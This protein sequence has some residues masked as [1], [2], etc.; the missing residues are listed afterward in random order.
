MAGTRHF[1]LCTL[2]PALAAATVALAQPSFPIDTTPNPYLPD[3]SLPAVA[4][5][6]ERFLLAW[7]DARDSSGNG[8]IAC[9]LF[10]TSGTVLAPGGFT[11]VH[12]TFKQLSPAA[13]GLE[14]LYLVVWRDQR[15]DATGDIYGARVTRSGVV[16]DP[17]GIRIC[18]VPGGQS[19]VTV[20]ASDSGW[21]VVWTDTRVGSDVLGARVSLGGAVLD[22]AGI[23]IAPLY[24]S[25]L[26]PAV[27]SDGTDYFVV[28]LNIA[29]ID[30]S[31][32]GVRVSA[33]GQVIGSGIRVAGDNSQGTRPAEPA[34]AFDGTNYLVVWRDRA[35]TNGV[36]GRFVTQDGSLMESVFTICDRYATRPRI[37]FDGVRYFVCWVD[38]TDP[39]I[40]A[41]SVRPDGSV[42]QDPLAVCT[43]TGRQ[44]DIAV[45]A[46]AS[47]YLLAWSDERMQYC[48]YVGG[49]VIDTSGA[50]VRRD[51]FAAQL[52]PYCGNQR[53]VRVCA[54]SETYFGVWES[55]EPLRYSYRTQN[56]VGRPLDRTG[57]AMDRGT[58]GI[59]IHSFY[60]DS[61]PVVAGGDS[62][63]L[64]LY[65]W[66]YHGVMGV[67]VSKSGQILDP[68]GFQVFTFGTAQ[69]DVCFGGGHFL[70]VASNGAVRGALVSE[71]GQ[72][73]SP[74]VF[75]IIEGGGRPHVAF[76][77]TNFLVTSSDGNGYVYCKRVDTL[78]NVIDPQP[79]FLGQSHIYT[80]DPAVA[81][82][83]S[84]YLVTWPYYNS[85]P[86]IRAIR[87]RPN[88][89]VMDTAAFVV[90]DTALYAFSPST[91]RVCFDGR[92]FVVVWGC[93][94]YWDDSTFVAGV[95]IAQNGSIGTRFSLR[96][97][98]QDAGGISPDLVRGPG[99]RVLI[100]YCDVWDQP[101]PLLGKLRTYGC[102]L[103]SLVG[104]SELGPAGVE[105]TRLTASPNPFV[106][107][108]RINVSASD[109]G[110]R[111]VN[112]AG[113]AVRDLAGAGVLNWDGRDSRGVAVP[114]GVYFCRP[115]GSTSTPGL[116]LV[117]TE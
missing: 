32:C 2:L 4:S 14:S 101:G 94:A 64:A 96:T 8:D 36:R 52:A 53:R 20:A 37:V 76:D 81:F 17:A 13:A 46:T 56:T 113:Q 83:D 75:T 62:V 9:V 92:D 93:D 41:I 5:D 68:T 100:A 90:S 108:T 86:S 88:L 82:G 47:R 69:I 15:A 80:G 18:G 44:G 16:L 111:I 38:G 71:A 39:N 102:F 103:D 105:Q 65:Y 91:P 21:L 12:D 110:T 10:D 27:A 34:V 97:R 3:Q 106:R 30:S 78:G 50:C 61:T 74:G 23:P 28:W 115:R 79:Q 107:M 72:V 114:P 40:Y 55:D 7:Q 89:T 116:K 45:A 57:Q 85:W 67:R 33:G 26:Q 11:V 87:V 49:A 29:D 99:G 35:V 25:Q 43:A 112:A 104:V 73:V 54:D 1:G 59:G 66:W 77:G 63:Y 48:R 58:I 84:V 24:G 70:A 31:V 51:M 6:G 22:P 98:S 109:N 60:T 19:E 117:K 95:K 42:G